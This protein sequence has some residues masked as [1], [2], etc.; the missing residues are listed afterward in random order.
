MLD[1]GV[2][3]MLEQIISLTKAPLYAGAG[4]AARLTAAVDIDQLSTH[5]DLASTLA[6][7]C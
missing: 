3:I 1:F 6:V 5:A 4:R 7:T 2:T